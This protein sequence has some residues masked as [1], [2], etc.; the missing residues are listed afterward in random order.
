[1]PPLERLGADALAS[2]LARIPSFTAASKATL[3][4]V[5]IAIAR[6]IAS[7]QSA[8]Q[9]AMDLGMPSAWRGVDLN[10][11]PAIAG[12]TAQADA[13]AAPAPQPAAAR[14]APPSWAK[15]IVPIALAKKTTARVVVLDR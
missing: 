14:P 15:E 2:E 9:L 4:S 13:Q 1:M 11:P 3:D 7:G 5:R 12:R 8:D 10:K 6:A